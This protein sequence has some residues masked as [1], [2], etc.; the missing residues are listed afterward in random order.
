M[1]GTLPF[2]Q[3]SNLLPVHWLHLYQLASPGASEP[4]LVNKW[5][6]L[7]QIP[8]NLDF[9][10]GRRAVIPS[11]IGAATPQGGK[12]DDIPHVVGVMTFLM[13]VGR[14]APTCGW[15]DFTFHVW[16]GAITHSTRGRGSDTFHVWLGYWLIPRVVGVNNIPRV[17]GAM[18]SHVWLGR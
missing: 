11:V 6:N 3:W 15:G 18:T 4:V 17:V 8:S 7:S 9:P 12:S 1:L 2:K 5:S 14:W 16:F 13:Q 10:H